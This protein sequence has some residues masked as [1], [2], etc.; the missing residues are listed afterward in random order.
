M[1]KI[2][3]IIH[4]NFK[5]LIRS[6]TSALIVV[7]GPLLVMLLIGA[8][9]NTSKMYDIKIGSYS[10]AYNELSEELITQLSGDQFVVIKTESREAC[11][12]GVKSSEFQV[13]MVIPANLQVEEE[14]GGDIIFYV[15]YSRVNLV[16]IV[17]ESLSKQVSTKTSEIST[18]LTQKLLDIVS[19]TETEFVAKRDL[20][21]DLTNKNNEVVSGLNDLQ[22]ELSYFNTSLG[23]GGIY[24]F[25]N[26]T[27]KIRATNLTESELNYVLD[28]LGTAESQISLKIR[29]IEGLKQNIDTKKTSIS[30]ILSETE[31]NIGAI[32]KG[33]D[34]IA[35]QMHGLNI[36][37]AEKIVSPIK[38]VIEPIDTQG[39]THLSYMFPTLLVL[40]I[41]FVSIVLSAALVIREKTSNAFFRNFITPTND[42]LFIIGNFLTNLLIVA[43]QIVIILIV[44]LILFKGAI[45]VNLHLTILA[46]LL[47]S[48][49]FILLGMLIG[50]IFKSEE[51]ATLG[52][53]SIASIFLF[54]SNTIL[55]IESLPGY[56]IKLANFNPFII[57]EWIIRKLVLFQ[58][59]IAD[60]SKQ[61]LILL[62][63]I[64]VLSAFIW[65]SR[66]MAKESHRIKKHHITLSKF[67]IDKIMDHIKIRKG[68]LKK[69]PRH[70]RTFI[71]RKESLLKHFGKNKKP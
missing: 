17:I 4:K 12:E 47:I 30:S 8:A 53:I 13:C 59:G 60:L 37:S 15:D 32:G 26:A 69:T 41:M 44:A 35:K 28:I 11:V 38:T 24:D 42:L 48:T 66:E 67:P 16:W 19:K 49:V 7:F 64:A 62:A 14:S 22:K 9:F 3:N 20:I 68:D 51:T 50:Y 61:I 40:I 55:P 33:A 23:S 45:I 10:D 46:L 36:K 31:S 65:V 34:E 54:F 1:L 71:F 18:Q 29:T 39:T 6:K 5:L 58:S 57:G 52:A 2:F 25:E 63:Y 21:Y 27:A 43:T 70:L 56:I